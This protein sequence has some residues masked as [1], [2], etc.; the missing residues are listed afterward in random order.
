[1]TGG[2]MGRERGNGKVKVKIWRRR[3]MGRGRA[4]WRGKVSCCCRRS[5][6]GRWSCE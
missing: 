6:I 5:G 3:V 1:M 4:I 2:L